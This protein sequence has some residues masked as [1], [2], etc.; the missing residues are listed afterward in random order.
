MGLG[1]Y[2]FE[3]SVRSLQIIEGQRSSDIKKIPDVPLPSMPDEAARIGTGEMPVPIVYIG[4]SDFALLRFH[5]R[6]HRIHFASATR[7]RIYIR[8]SARTF[9]FVI[10]IHADLAL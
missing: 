3:F 4:R 2:L 1:L 9:L 5:R 8:F 10:D 7:F 6:I